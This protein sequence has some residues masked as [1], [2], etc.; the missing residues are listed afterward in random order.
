MVR[1]CSQDFRNSRRGKLT[2]SLLYEQPG[3]V[4]PSGGR[5]RAEKR[6]RDR[7]RKTIRRRAIGGPTGAFPFFASLL[8]CFPASVFSS[9]EKRITADLTAPDGRIGLRVIPDAK[10]P[11]T[12]ARAGV[13][14]TFRGVPM[15]ESAQNMHKSI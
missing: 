14:M 8:P 7:R 9:L 5:C 3:I 13:F 1:R 12:S 4:L 11:A 10:V 2:P 6:A 15:H